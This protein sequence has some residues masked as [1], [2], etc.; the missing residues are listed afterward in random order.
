M[1]K[2]PNIK[3][4]NKENPKSSSKNKLTYNHY[5]K[6][7]H[8]FKAYNHYHKNGHPTII[9][10]LTTTIKAYIQKFEDFPKQ[11]SY[12]MGIHEYDT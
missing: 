8:T 3:N 7:G 5:H 12:N 1:S 2:Y 6:N 4:I 9:N 10:L 11:A